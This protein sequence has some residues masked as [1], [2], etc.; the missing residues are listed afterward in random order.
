MLEKIL[1]ILRTTSIKVNYWKIFIY[2]FPNKEE[3]VVFETR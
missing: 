1:I 2:N 3:Y